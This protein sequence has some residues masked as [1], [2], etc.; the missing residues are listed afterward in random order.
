MQCT[1][2]QLKY[3]GKRIAPEEAR[4]GGISGDLRI[5]RKRPSGMPA[6]E[7]K[8]LDDKGHTLLTLTQPEVRQ[9]DATGMLMHG[10]QPG[11]SGWELV[12]QVW[13]CE[14]TC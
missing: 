14:L 1:V 8:L 9:I 6:V 5:T 10:Y 11:G 12:P 4:T 3:D 2:F 7:A 13:W